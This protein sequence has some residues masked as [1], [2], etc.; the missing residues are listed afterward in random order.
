MFAKVIVDII[1]S[2]V[3]KYFEYRVPQDMNLRVGF[4]VKVPFGKGN[5]LKEGYVL[6][7]S[8]TC[9]YNT[10]SIKEVASVLSDYATLLPGQI[11][12]AHMI[13]RYYHTTLATALRLMF[14]AE[15]RGG[16]VGDKYERQITY[17]LTDEQYKAAVCCDANENRQDKSAKAKSYS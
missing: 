17:S 3:D 15:M 16:R 12:L 14:P 10:D 4:R 2:S 11:R 13:R 9:E 5:A 6:A 7:L 8:E 1:H